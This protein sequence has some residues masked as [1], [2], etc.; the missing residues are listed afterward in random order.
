MSNAP[1]IWMKQPPQQPGQTP[2]Y[3]NT[4]AIT[5]NGERVVTFA[6][7]HGAEGDHLAHDALGGPAPTFDSRGDVQDRQS[8]NRVI[9]AVSDFSG[10]KTNL[11]PR[12]AAMRAGAQALT[13]L[14]RAFAR[15]AGL[16]GAQ[17]P[18]RGA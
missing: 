7:H 6:E 17:Q 1:L 12:S 9:V 11:L 3:I 4:V 5:A 14:L 16:N 18:D 8:A 10:H 2:Y 15:A 13:A